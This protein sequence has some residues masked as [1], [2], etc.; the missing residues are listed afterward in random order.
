MKAASAGSHVM[1]RTLMGRPPVESV[2]S[3]SG[4]SRSSLHL[5]GKSL[6]FPLPFARNP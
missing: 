2:R 6:S 5:N 4:A 1:I 3:A